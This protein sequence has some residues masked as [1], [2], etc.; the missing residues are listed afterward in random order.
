MINQLIVRINAKELNNS[1]YNY[2]LINWVNNNFKNYCNL[3]NWTWNTVSKELCKELIK[4]KIVEKMQLKKEKELNNL[5]QNSMISFYLNLFSFLCG[6]SYMPKGY[7]LDVKTIEIRKKKDLEQNEE[8]ENKTNEKNNKKKKKKKNKKNKNLEEQDSIRYNLGKNLNKK[9]LTKVMSSLREIHKGYTIFDKNIDPILLEWFYRSNFDL[10]DNEHKI[11]LLVINSLKCL[12]L[13]TFENLF[14]LFKKYEIEKEIE[15]SHI[16]KTVINNQ[17]P[18]YYSLNWLLDLLKRLLI[19][20]PNKLIFDSRI[21][22]KNMADLFSVWFNPDL[23]FF[24]KISFKDSIQIFDLIILYLKMI[25]KLGINNA[26]DI[27]KKILKDDDNNDDDDDENNNDENDNKKKKKKKKKQEEKDNKIVLKKFKNFNFLKKECNNDSIQTIIDFLLPIIKKEDEKLKKIKKMKK[28]GKLIKEVNDEQNIDLN[29]SELQLNK[30]KLKFELKNEFYNF[31]IILLNQ[32]L[33]ISSITNK[34]TQKNIYNFISKLLNN[35]NYFQKNLLKLL[36]SFLIKNPKYF[37]NFLKLSY[38]KKLA[39]QNNKS[40]NNN[41]END[42]VDESNEEKILTLKLTREL[43]P[44]KKPLIYLQAL[45]QTI[46]KNP[47]LWI[48]EHEIPIS[49]NFLYYII[50]YRLPVA[51][52]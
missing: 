39:N 3:L 29:N 28:D 22:I 37:D 9:K 17:I 30:K 26:K 41:K 44:S 31:S 2:Q 5:N 11:Q 16:N 45:T 24:S 12:N 13:K 50:K 36:K 25:K 42:N 1:E 46:G 48:N 14:P 19:R 15:I 51:R 18:K 27:F 20:L 6:T 33:K 38:N 49:K 10:I 34:K 40:Q 43:N 52:K 8:N 23:K 4:K 21:I 35:G 7:Y 47:K 32:L